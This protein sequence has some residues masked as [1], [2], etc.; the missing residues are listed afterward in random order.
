MAS[1]R[2]MNDQQ[3]I[4]FKLTPPSDRGVPQFDKDTT[5]KY[6]IAAQI[7]LL[8]ILPEAIW[9]RL[10]EKEYFLATQL[11][12]FSRH[13]STGLQLDHNRD[14]MQQFP[15]AK[16][17][18]SILNQFYFTIKQQCLDA[19]ERPELDVNTAAKCLAAI[20]LLENCQIEKLLT[21]FTQSR[22]KAFSK[23]VKPDSTDAH[24]ASQE[25]RTKIL[26][27]LELLN[28]TV[29]LLAQC[30]IS[31]EGQTS[32]LDAELSRITAANAP[33]T[34]SLI[35]TDMSPDLEATIPSMIL[36]FK[37]VNVQYMHKEV[38]VLTLSFFCLVDPISK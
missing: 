22:A 26:A 29:T 5:K 16:R 24:R 13:I 37:Y 10:D 28:Q 27:G 8:T 6:S 23:I 38:F 32:Y 4:G 3:L 15:F 9:T 12:I 30:F 2:R 33:T 21:L 35:K 25:V 18:W 20:L 17:Q 1:C 14:A 31:G 34:I 19:L 7:R 36:K 11:Y